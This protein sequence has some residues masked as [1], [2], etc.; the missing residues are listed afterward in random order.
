MS[1][2]KNKNNLWA[3]VPALLAAAAIA[4]IFTLGNPEEFMS[5]DFK[6]TILAVSAGYCLFLVWSLFS[7]NDRIL[8]GDNSGRRTGMLVVVLIFAFIV[9]IYIGLMISGYPSD[10]A[11]WTGWSSAAAGKGF[12]EVYSDMSFMDYPPGYIYIL[13]ILGSIGNLMK[14]DCGTEAYNLLMKIPSIISDIIMA[15]ILYRLCAKKLLF[16]LGLILAFAYVMN[17]LIILDSAGWGQIDAILTLAIAGYLIA[18]YRKNILGAS[19][20]FTV[21]LLIKPQ[22]LFFGPVL[23]VIFIKYISDRGWGQAIKA[24]FISVFSSVALFALAVFPFTG[25]KP[26]YWIFEKYLGTIGSYNYITLNSANVFGLFGLNWVPTD[27]V[28]LGLSLGVWGIIGIVST[29]VLYF[30][31]GFINRGKK[32]IFIL[33]VML[34]TGIYAFGLKMHERYLFP[35]IAILIIAYIYDN[36][37]SILAM[38]SVLSVAVF[39]NTAQVLAVIHIPPDD[40]LFKITSGVVVAA[41]IW[42]VVFCFVEVAKSVRDSKVNLIEASDKAM[43]FSQPE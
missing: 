19:L 23:A 11:C 22:M 14:I 39:I 18:L 21:G 43:G 36:K 2:F 28:K 31:L 41:Y 33:T 5:G 6:I 26:W 34:M 4:G 1:E 30:V 35:V 32:N 10:M 37:K 13:H 25:D 24:F 8:G 20:F 12:F 38:F 3:L 29:V 9:R 7:M 17:P 15:W 27:T 42:I 16:T 40:L